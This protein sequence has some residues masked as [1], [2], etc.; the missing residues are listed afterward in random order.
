M[1]KETHQLQL[2]KE[3]DMKRVYFITGASL[4][5]GSIFGGVCGILHA[6]KATRGKKR[7]VEYFGMQEASRIGK[8]SALA[9]CSIAMSEYII[10]KI[11]SGI[12]YSLK[13]LQ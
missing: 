11:P 1:K 13:M 9:S 10:G 7:V 8:A 6:L 5:A 4:I 12:E 3:N 2:Y